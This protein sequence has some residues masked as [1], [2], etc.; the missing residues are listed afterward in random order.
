MLPL[1]SPAAHLAAKVSVSSD[2]QADPRRLAAI[3]DDMVRTGGAALGPQHG[4]AKKAYEK[5]WANM[6]TRSPP[7]CAACRP[8]SSSGMG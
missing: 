3:Y 5:A 7:G 8:P 2:Q 6:P 4:Q 1:C